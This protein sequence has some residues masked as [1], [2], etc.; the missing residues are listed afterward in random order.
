MSK[1]HLKPV[2][3]QSADIYRL[4]SK[5][6][7]LKVKQIADH[8]GIL[9]NAVYRAAKPLIE[10]GMVE[11]LDG[12]P[13][14]F[15][16]VVANSAINWYSRA[17]AQSFRQEFGNLISKPTNDFLPT[18]TFIKDRQYMLK[19]CEHEARKAMSHINYIVS[20]HRIP[21]S[22]V[23]AYRK[24]S[25]VGVR[26]RAIIQNTPDTTDN[27]LERYHKMGVEVRYLPNIGIRLFIF[28]GRVAVLTSYDDTK[29][30]RAF[31]I[32]FTHVSVA[33]QLDHLFEQRWLE[34]KPI[35]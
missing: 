32:R 27:S 25:T 12:Y 17:A 10:F 9:P 2:T 20:G 1:K 16:A 3:G 15:K 34:A 26:V 19:I 18:I 4:L 29:S 22:T 6:G 21:D 7:S 14:R 35:E 23:L 8:L 30:S 33:S 24:A 5:S 13:I 11:K 31:G 28:D